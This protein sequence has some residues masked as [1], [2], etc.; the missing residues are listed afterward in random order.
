MGMGTMNQIPTVGKYKV[1][2]WNY[3]DT[4]KMNRSPTPGGMN[5][6]KCNHH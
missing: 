4:G 5:V 1:I 6:D 2:S 3:V